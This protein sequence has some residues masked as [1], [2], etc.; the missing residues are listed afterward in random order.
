MSKNPLQT[1]ICNRRRWATYHLGTDD[2]VPSLFDQT[3]SLR[4]NGDSIRL[5][6]DSSYLIENSSHYVT[7]S[8]PTDLIRLTPPLRTDIQE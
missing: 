6:G 3:D 5:G 1:L 7:R 8:V 2:K 4:L